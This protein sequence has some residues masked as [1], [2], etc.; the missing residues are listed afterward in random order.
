MQLLKKS[1]YF[2]LIALTALSVSCK[3]DNSLPINT[4]VLDGVSKNIESAIMDSDYYSQNKYEIYLMLDQ[5]NEY[6]FYEFDG[7]SHLGKNVDLRKKL[8]GTGFLVIFSMMA[9]T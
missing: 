3:K 4:F 2:L 5:W 8:A 1:F 6:L 7:E 9:L